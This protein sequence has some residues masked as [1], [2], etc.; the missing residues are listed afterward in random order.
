MVRALCST[1]E[2]PGH[3]VPAGGADLVVRCAG[4]RIYMV[5]RSVLGAV[6][7]EFCKTLFLKR[8]S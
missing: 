1:A 2:R 6:Q 8:L 3:R 4:A 5:L 7:G